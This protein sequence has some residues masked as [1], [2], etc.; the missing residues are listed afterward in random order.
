MFDDTRMLTVHGP[1]QLWL[2]QA[3]PSDTGLRDQQD[4]MSYPFFSLAKGARMQPIRYEQGPVSISVEGVP[5]IGIA[6]IWDA[7]VLIWAAS[8][9]AA[10][11][12]RGAPTS[13]RIHTSIGDMLRF[14]QRGT[15]LHDYQRL[16]AALNRLQA[17]T[18][19]TSLRQGR[20]LHQHRFSWIAEWQELAHD[21]GRSAGIEILLADWFY[22]GAL[23]ESTLLSLHPN[24]FRLTGGMQRWLYRLV[25]KHGGRQRGGWR[26]ALRQ[27]YARSGSVQR[28]SDFALEIR[29]LVSRPL[30]EYALHLEREHDEEYLCF[31]R[32]RKGAS[33]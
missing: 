21:N 27:L 14:I 4:L 24:Y 17:T 26:F 25:R 23:D 5:N 19:S 30:L 1:V 22:T 10:A 20:L 16:R 6:T 8:Q 18:I 7:D 32:L 15:S 11:I 9:I 12:N 29:R 31:R 3:M 28:Y 33:T 13:P 2:F